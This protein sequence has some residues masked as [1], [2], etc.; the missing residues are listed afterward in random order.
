MIMRMEHVTTHFR[1]SL[2]IFKLDT[3]QREVILEI[4]HKHKEYLASLESAL[5]EDEQ[6]A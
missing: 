5:A 6:T 2:T 4:I 1:T 3:A